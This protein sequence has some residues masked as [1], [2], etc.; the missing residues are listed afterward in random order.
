M[1]E[2]NILVAILAIIMAI[3]LTMSVFAMEAKAPETAKNDTT[4]SEAYIPS[5]ASVVLLNDNIERGA[6]LLQTSIK[7]NRVE[8]IIEN[9][10]EEVIEEKEEEP[11]ELIMIIEEPIEII[12]EEQ[13]VEEE[14]IVET[15]E[16]LEQAIIEY[17]GYE[18]A[19][20]IWSYMKDLGWSD[21]VCAG[22]M[23]NIMVEVGGQTLDINYNIYDASGYY[24]GICQW[25]G[26]AYG[27]VHGADLKTQCDFLRD[28]IQ[29]EMD[30]YGYAFQTG[31][32]FEGFLQLTSPSDVALAFAM[33]YERCASSSYGIRQSSAEAAYS[34][35]VG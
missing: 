26:G 32:D 18:A 7:V 15:V 31:M 17:D 19:A 2:K 25:N 30:T 23:G 22:I 5:E 27:A 33:C 9:T 16:S 35:F 1:K 14:E 28:T 8:P 4:I 24:Y 11:T 20:Q 29:K 34:Y 21:A 3:S 13:V 10:K 12:T 6:Y